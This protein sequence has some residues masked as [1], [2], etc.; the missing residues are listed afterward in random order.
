MI[1]PWMTCFDPKWPAEMTHFCKILNN[2]IWPSLEADCNA[3]LVEEPS[4][5]E[6]E[7]ACC[8][9]EEGKVEGGELSPDAILLRNVFVINRYVSCL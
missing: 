1:W 7:G 3:E 8:C 4:V 6:D 2:S 9:V 5:W